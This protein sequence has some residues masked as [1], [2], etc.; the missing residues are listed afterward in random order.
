MFAFDELRKKEWD[1][2]SAIIANLASAFTGQRV[3]AS[4]IHPFRQFVVDT[5]LHDPGRMYEELR[6][7]PWRES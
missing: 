4:Q 7:N 2:T 1:H 5:E 3:T 6:R